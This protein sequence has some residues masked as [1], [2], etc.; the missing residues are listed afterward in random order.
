[1]NTPS[2]DDLIAAIEARAD[3]PL[4]RL[5]EAALLGRHLDEVADHLIGH[6]VDRARR[7]G[8]SWTTIGDSLGVTKQAAQ[9]RFVPSD[10]ATGE[11]DVRIFARYTDGARQVVIRSQEQARAAALPE[12][13]PGHLLLALLQD[14]DV[15]ALVPAPT[16]VEATTRAVLGT[17]DAPL[18][19]PIPFSANAK[20][21]L[22][23]GHREALRLG[24]EKIWPEHLL[25][26]VLTDSPDF[27]VT[28]A[29][30]ETALRARD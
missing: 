16:E 11:A 18:D 2:L 1:M 7:S 8:A 22:E 23:L 29:D 24:A 19:G 27:G 12:I 21:A 9:K 17:G 14:P 30:V 13:Q 3:D 4:D 15:A 5:T 25:L 10:P 28:R 26:G 20:K 6:F